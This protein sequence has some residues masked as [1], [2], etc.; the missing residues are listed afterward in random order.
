MEKKY[1]NFCQQFDGKTQIRALHFSL[2]MFLIE[3]RV[4]EAKDIEAFNMENVKNMLL[5]NFFKLLECD[6]SK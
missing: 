5:D 3:Q 2:L 1:W 4:F 6:S